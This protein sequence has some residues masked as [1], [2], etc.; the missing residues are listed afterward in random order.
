ML[1]QAGIDGQWSYRLAGFA[2]E[3]Q[4]GSTP[5]SSGKGEHM[6]T[7][8]AYDLAVVVGNYVDNTGAQKNQYQNI[9]VVLEKDDGGKFILLNRDFNPAGTPYDAS[10]GN[11]IMVS[12]FAPKPQDGQQETPRKGKSTA[13]QAA[14][15]DIPF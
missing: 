4:A 7:R 1:W 6:S 8:K 11:T 12:M 9:G 15:D 14:N 3:P 10:K 2:G 13:A 5:D